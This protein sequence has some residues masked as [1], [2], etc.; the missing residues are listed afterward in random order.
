VGLVYPWITATDF[1]ANR[2]AA[3]SRGDD[4]LR[5]I[6]GDTADYVAELI[7]EAVE[8][9]AAEVYAANVK[10]VMESSPADPDHSTSR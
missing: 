3:E 2:A 4:R 7:L 10:R 6:Q 8:T 1:T 5:T 9:E